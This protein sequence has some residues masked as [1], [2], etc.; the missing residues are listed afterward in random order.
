MQRVLEDFRLG[1][2][3]TLPP[4]VHYVLSRVLKWNTRWLKEQLE[5]SNPPTLGC[6]TPLQHASLTY[7]SH[8]QYVA[9]FRPLLLHELWSSAVEHY[10]RSAARHHSSSNHVFCWPQFDGESVSQ[11]VQ[12]KRGFIILYYTVGIPS[13]VEH[14]SMGHLVTLYLRLLPSAGSSGQCA[15]FGYIYDRRTTVNHY[16]GAQ[17]DS[18]DS[19]KLVY[20][21]LR[22]L[23]F[24]KN[25]FSI[26][27]WTKKVRMKI[28]CQLRP[29]LRKFSNIE[30][31]QQSPL[32][33]AL[34]LPDAADR[35]HYFSTP[36][37]TQPLVF[38]GEL[39][40]VQKEVVIAVGAA[41]RQALDTPYLGI[42]QGP[43]GTGK[44]R[45][46]VALIEQILFS[47]PADSHVRLLICAPSNTAVDEITE[48]IAAQR[49]T[50]KARGHQ[51]RLVRYGVGLNSSAVARKYSIDELVRSNVQKELRVR[52]SYFNNEI[53]E[54]HERL[55]SVL[56]K[57]RAASSPGEICRLKTCA[58]Q[59][60]KRLESLQS[61]SKV[62]GRELR[63]LQ[64]KC[65]TRLLR[66]SNIVVTTL[67]S[68][69]GTS[70]DVSPENCSNQSSYKGAFTCCIVDEAGQCTEP[71][72]LAPLLH[73]IN[74]IILVGDSQQL[75]PTVVSQTARRHGLGS[76]L[77]ER[78]EQIFLSSAPSSPCRRVFR[79]SIQYR[80]HEQICRWPASRFYG[81]GA[82]LTAPCVYEQLRKFSCLQPYRLFD[83]SHCPPP[84]ERGSTAPRSVSS[85]AT[86]YRSNSLS[87]EQEA[88]LVVLLCRAVLSL[89]HQRAPSIGVITPYQNQRNLI[90]DLLKRHGCV[91]GVDVRTIDGFQGQQR[92]VIIVSAVR[93]QHCGVGFLADYRRLNVA[94]TRARAALYICCCCT[95]LQVD[96]Y[97]STLFADASSRGLVTRLRPSV[98]HGS[99]DGIVSLIRSS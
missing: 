75:P 97:W 73:R 60:A 65:R 12:T 51:V 4:E 61:T 58:R 45:T 43:P 56:E 52:P 54:L 10:W 29:S 22:V 46:I 19:S 40:S 81:Q 6:S 80:M 37:C 34:L 23:V 88:K 27:D 82:L 17:S 53:E 74:K 7:Q 77:M 91:G 36:Q 48:R 13:G 89:C 28:V 47:P 5:Q 69:Y 1:N 3:V 59:I 16:A 2:G 11:Q 35:E 83:I 32:L 8:A 72:A 94:L 57:Q 71:E 21:Y 87:N 44:T 18:A 31:V 20:F 86:D 63:A 90:A 93:G 50:L 85:T 92:D 62:S 95:T 55:R 33:P 79:L 42:I 99:F 49:G 41:A 25:Q 26:V 14:P 70:I 30:R 96:E 24:Y 76:S 9:T 38:Q 39:N 67:G 15:L 66:H 84:V 98:L 68:C 78:L 64:Q